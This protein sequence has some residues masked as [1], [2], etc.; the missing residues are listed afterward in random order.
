MNE[1]EIDKR[2]APKEYKSGT[3]QEYFAILQWLFIY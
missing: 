3:I 1:S 2:P